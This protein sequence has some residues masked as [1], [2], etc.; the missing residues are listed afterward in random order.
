MSFKI[1][2]KDYNEY[3]EFGLSHFEWYPI[4]DCLFPP[5]NT[6]YLFCTR[7][8]RQFIGYMNYYD[9]KNLNEDGLIREINFNI[10]TSR[11]SS[12]LVREKVVAFMLLPPKPG[13]IK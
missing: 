13:F 1:N 7:N 12:K 2:P 11:M 8:G 4:K 5:R 9:H 6:S 10:Y 3:D